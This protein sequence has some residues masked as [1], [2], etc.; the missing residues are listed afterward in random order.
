MPKRYPTTQNT[1]A[2]LQRPLSPTDPWQ[3]AGVSSVNESTGGWLLS[4]LD[5]MTLLFAFFVLLFAYQKAV[6]PTSGKS[7]K[8]AVAAVKTQPQA[9]PPR[10][11]DHGGA[12]KPVTPL[13]AVAAM[14]TQA[15]LK[16]SAHAA[17]LHAATDTLPN[18]PGGLTERALSSAILT[19]PDY[20]ARL[21]ERVLAPE[22]HNRRVEITHDER[23]VRVEISDAILFDPG[24]AE[25]RGDGRGLIDRI[26][27]ILTV[28]TGAIH[29]EGHTDTTPIANARF[30]SNWELS[31]ARATAVTRYLVDEGLPAERLRAVGLADTHP[32]TDN[33]TPEHRARN[34]RVTLVLG[35]QAR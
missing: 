7:A 8:T 9:Q 11:K 30:P 16:A 33:K 13:P 32:L 17:S 22:A 5:V 15:I 31:S 4:Y 18:A 28:Q 23:Q 35:E 20:A 12:D 25:L 2:S 3:A 19:H 27:P 24:S 34:R 29:V 1:P 10:S 6:A 14:Q 26:V 21:V